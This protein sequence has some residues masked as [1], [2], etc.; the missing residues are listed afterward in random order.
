MFLT[1]KSLIITNYHIVHL[2]N[3]IKT[4][5]NQTFNLPPSI[6][7]ANDLFALMEI[8]KATWE[9]IEKVAITALFTLQKG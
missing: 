4:N 3:D 1:K 6:Y 7:A 2:N 9:S 8:A 5:N